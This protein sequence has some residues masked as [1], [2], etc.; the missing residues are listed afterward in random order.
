L[1]FPSPHRK[2]NSYSSH[3][4]SVF[5][6]QYLEIRGHTLQ[7]TTTARSSKVQDRTKGN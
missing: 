2:D 6:D 1:V 3:H 5:Q 4:A 7:S